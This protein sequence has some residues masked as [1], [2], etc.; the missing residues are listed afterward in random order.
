MGKLSWGKPTIYIKDL[1][2]EG[3]KWTKIPTPVK[4]STE[5]TPTKGDKK[6]APLEG[7]ENEDVKFAKNT[8]DLAYQIRKSSDK[9]MPFTDVDGIVENHFAVALIPENADAPGFIIDKST[10]SAEDKF[11]AEDGAVV[12]YT[13]SVLKP[14]TGNQVKWGKV[15]VTEAEG[16]VS[17]IA[18]A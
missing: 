9:T 2:T 16:V 14:D 6:E 12:T 3:A 11:T 1:D 7:G 10:V 8:Y 15:T 5:L 4:D 17:N 18:I 13:H